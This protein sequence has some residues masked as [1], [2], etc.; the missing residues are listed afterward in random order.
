MGSLIGQDQASLGKESFYSL[1]WVLRVHIGGV[2]G[3]LL[4]S[5]DLELKQGQ[6]DLSSSL[7]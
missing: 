1:A 7:Y 3:P 6:S 5:S 2:V 4:S